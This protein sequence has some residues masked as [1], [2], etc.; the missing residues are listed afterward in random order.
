VLAIDPITDHIV[1]IIGIRQGV[2]HFTHAF[3]SVVWLRF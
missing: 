1:L 2:I 3:L